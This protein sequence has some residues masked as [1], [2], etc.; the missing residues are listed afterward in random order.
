MPTEAIRIDSNAR[1]AL[2]IAAAAALIFG[3][4]FSGKWG[5]ANTVATRTDIPE[6]AEFAADLAPGDPYAHFSNAGLL[7]KTLEPDS[8]ARSLTEY[9]TAVSLSPNNYLFWLG[10]GRAR[11]RDGDRPAAE[12]AYR[13]ALVLS[14]N[15]SRVRWALGNVLVRQDKVDEGFA[16]IRVAVESDPVFS[17]PAVTAAWQVF[18]GDL[19]RVKA[20][21]GDAPATNIE[22]AKFLAAQKRFDEA[23]AIWETVPERER[24]TTYRDAGKELTAK[25]VQGFKFRSAA[26]IANGTAEQQSNQ[27]HVGQVTNAGFESGVKLQN[28]DFFDWQI[29][30]G[31]Y[32]QIALT[33]GQKKEGK[34]SLVLLFSSSS[35]LDFRTVQQTVAVE[36]EKKY[37]LG[38]G[39]RME[40]KTNAVF[41]WE[42][43]SAADGKRLS[44]T[45]PLASSNSWSQAET[46]IAVPADIDGVTIRLVRENCVSLSCTVSGNIW[47]DDFA[48]S[49]VN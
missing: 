8:I 14:P 3:A 41:R 16:D 34:Y 29:G 36:P 32:P 35:N 22:L 46:E 38:I 11:E 24:E 33:D 30:Q 37:K 1:R 19:S 42:I 48:L 28:A 40:L 43:I 6:I 21:L 13:Y 20:A 31:V 18:D 27:A 39:Y 26:R 9:E 7:E 44:V 5:F 23:F 10:L 45:E 49:S 25:F 15:Y 17:A 47:F 4:Y 2:L 12:R